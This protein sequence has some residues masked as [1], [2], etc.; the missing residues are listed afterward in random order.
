MWLLIRNSSFICALCLCIAAAPAN[1]I[2]E[3]YTRKPTN[4]LHKVNNQIGL[5]LS[6]KYF[7]YEEPGVMKN[8]ST[9]P[10]VE[11]FARSTADKFYLDGTVSFHSGNAQYDGG[12][13]F[14][15]SSGVE[16]VPYST[17][18]SYNKLTYLTG[19]LG[20]IVDSATDIQ[21]IP[22]IESGNRIYS[23]PI[24]IITKEGKSQATRTTNNFHYAVGII[25]NVRLN[26]ECVISPEAFIGQVF[27]GQVTYTWS[28]NDIFKFFLNDG[29]YYSLGI[30]GNYFINNAMSINAAVIYKHYNFGASKNF[31]LIRGNPLAEPVGINNDFTVGLGVSYHF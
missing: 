20:Y 7:K 3:D 19:R 30:K 16:V 17:K 29:T 23:M 5:S 28:G 31:Y 13:Q 2:Q 12:M 10:G 6:G 27:I 11:I 4:I 25:T 18:D 14:I 24:D 21:I 8:Y 1:A 9:I 22:A 15:T 26:N